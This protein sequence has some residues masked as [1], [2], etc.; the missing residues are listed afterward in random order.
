MQVKEVVI[1]AAVRTPIGSFG[2][3]LASLSATE[4]G[5]IALKGALDKAGVAPE[6]VEQVIMGNVIS[7]N[8]GQAP[9]RQAAKKAGLPDTVECTTVNKVCASGSKAIMMG[10]QAIML[11]Q[12]EVIL[13]GGMESMSNV[14]YYLDK[15]RFGAKYGNGQID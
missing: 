5:A 14:P 11:G 2:G 9:A 13:A 3:A 1:V 8:L 4:L 12:A 7:A 6:L 10:A 15:A